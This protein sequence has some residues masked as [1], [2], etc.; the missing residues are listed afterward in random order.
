MRVGDLEFALE[1]GRTYRIGEGA[2]CDVRAACGEPIALLVELVDGEAR[3]TQQSTGAVLLLRSGGSA[4]L[5]GIEC[6]VVEDVHGAAILPDPTLARDATANATQRVAQTIAPIA[7]TPSASLRASNTEAT[8]ADMLADELKRAPWLALSLVVHALLFLI[9]W[10]VF[11]AMPPQKEPPPRYGYEATIEPEPDAM[12]PA[13]DVP[14]VAEKLEVV[15]PEPQIEQPGGSEPIDAPPPEEPEASPNLLARIGSARVPSASAV[16]GTGSNAGQGTGSGS[17]MGAGTGDVMA[18]GKGSAGF[19]KTVSELRRS[20]LEIVFVFDSTGSM[21]SSIRATKD[22][23]ANMLDVLRALVPDARFSL[24]TY[25]D[26]GQGEEYLVRTLPLDRDFFA[27]VNWM[28]TVEADGGGDAPEAVLAGLREAFRQDFRRGARRVVVLA[29]DAP[30]HPR[31]LRAVREQTL[32]F[33]AAPTSAV[34]ALLT[35]GKHSTAADTFA[36]IA[37]AGRGECF[38][39]EDQKLLLRKVLTLAFGAAF[40]RDLD[41]VQQRLAAE[42]SSPPTWARDLARRG[43]DDLAAA[44]ASDS[45]PSA[46]VHALLRNP[47]RAA[48][49]TLVGVL[50]EPSSG[51]PG[52]QAAAHVLQRALELSQ[53]PIDAENPRPIPQA[54]AAQ[55]RQRALS[56]PE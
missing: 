23:I 36:E 34:H 5:S 35:S 26:K 55:L 24:V 47:S 29:G 22:G 21:G 31:D 28:Q 54:L 37:K 7:S 20:G 12:G 40:E 14:V 44:L 3:V 17:A 42:R 50:A 38:A 52:R 49:L 11:G 16:D 51:K 10:V 1:R 41:E 39:I 46:L 25:R 13:T 32:R 43:G 6:A 15:D 18:S 9:A 4:R 2:Q 53:C 19:R 27:A 45:I 33:A 48:M 56:L 30:P 8:F